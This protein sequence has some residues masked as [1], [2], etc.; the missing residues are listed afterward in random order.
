[1]NTIKNLTNIGVDALKCL[2]RIVSYYDDPRVGNQWRGLPG[3]D[4]QAKCRHES[5]MFGEARALLL[6]YSELNTIDNDEV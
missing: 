5:T 4:E 1:M 3:M 6:R 2:Q